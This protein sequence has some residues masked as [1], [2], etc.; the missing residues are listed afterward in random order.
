[1][2]PIDEAKAWSTDAWLP[3]LWHNQTVRWIVKQYTET[4]KAT[5]STKSEHAIQHHNGLSK[6]QR[7]QH[8]TNQG[9]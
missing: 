3:S 8:N 7:N 9:G 1:M 5:K 4:N 6:N 2:A